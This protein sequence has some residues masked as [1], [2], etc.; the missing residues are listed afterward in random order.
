MATKV[1]QTAATKDILVN[2][3]ADW[4]LQFRLCTGTKE[5][6]TPINIDG[7]KFKC[8]IRESADSDEVLAE[9]DCHIIDAKTGLMEVFFDDSVTGKIETDGGTYDDTSKFVWDVYAIEP[10]GDTTRIVNGTCYVSPGVS[11]DD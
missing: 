7:Y 6:H 3:G 2:Q 1:K 4:R 11:F 9:A 5:E 8:K 10:E